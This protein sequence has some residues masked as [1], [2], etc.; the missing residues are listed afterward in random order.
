MQG[1]TEILVQ[2][3]KAL[4]DPVRLR[5]LALCRQGEASVGELAGVLGLSQPRVSQQ[6]KILCDA[7]LLERFRDGQRV[8]YRLAGGGPDAAERRALVRL[9]P[10]DDPVFDDDGARLLALRGEALPREASAPGDREL[11]RAVL[12]LTVAGAVGDLL[13]VGCG[14]GRLL[15]LLASRASRAVGV[16]IDASAREFARA[17]LLLAG[18]G[19]CTLRKGD[20]YQLP[21][22]DGGFD[23]VILDDVLGGADRPVAVLSEAGRVLRPGGRL[24]VLERTDEAGATAL[25]RHLAR[26][27]AE[28]GLRLAPGRRV[29]GW[30]LAVARLPDERSVAA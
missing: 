18:L 13:D 10:A 20:M 27:C 26:C 11:H 14:R 16:D 4:G 15:K 24:L 29:P 2:R 9:L 28:A 7:G 23:T 3:M 21:F 1:G 19:N 6:L 17:E 12:D 8:Y 22:E 5:L 30:L 25:S